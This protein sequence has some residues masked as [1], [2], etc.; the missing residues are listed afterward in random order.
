M[1]LR[2]CLTSC[3]LAA[4]LTSVV[5]IGAEPLKKIPSGSKIYV[6][7][8]QGFDAYLLGCLA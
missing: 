8:E 7:A 3:M 5:S 1:T 6:E 2:S 4:I